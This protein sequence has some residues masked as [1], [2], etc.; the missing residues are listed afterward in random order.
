MEPKIE[1]ELEAIRPQLKKEA[2]AKRGEPLKG[3]K[4]AAKGK[5]NSAPSN[6]GSTERKRHGK[7]A[8]SEATAKLAKTA[9]VN[10]SELERSRP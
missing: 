2:D 4:N 6:G 5:K 9:G 1:K 10:R 8:R 7:G 3:N